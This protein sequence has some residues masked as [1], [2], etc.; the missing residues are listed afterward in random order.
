LI[1]VHLNGDFIRC[2]DMAAIQQQLTV[3]RNKLSICQFGV[4]EES[5]QKWT[6]FQMT[7]P[8]EY[9]N[10]RCF[11][12]KEFNTNN[13][14]QRVYLCAKAQERFKNSNK[15]KHFRID[16]NNYRKISSA[17]HYL[18]K[19]TENRTL[20]LA[21]T[22]PQWKAGFNPYKNENTLNECFSRF[23]ENLVATYDCKGYIAVRE[24]GK[25]DRRYHYHLLVNIPFVPFARLNAAWCHAIRDI[26]EFSKNA[27]TTNKENRLIS[28]SE[29]SRAVRYVCKY[30]SKSKN[31][32]SKSRVIFI[33]NNLFRKPFAVRNSEYNLYNHTGIM[34]LETELL[35]YKSL[36]VF[37]INDYCTAFR[38]NSNKDFDKICQEI[39]YPLFY[40]TDKNI[41]LYSF[42]LNTS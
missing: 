40:I 6:D 14:G 21:L 12:C 9:L 8:K 4:Y 32:C 34:N 23:V 37:K 20:F 39:I 24:L 26:C 3:S 1:N 38:I 41:D 35:K 15:T 7:R 42:P 18:M 2:P 22:F 16:N 27:L 17:A 25:I 19:T 30:I 10:K 29:S 31:Q 28:L 13:D 36:S 33:S 5:C 11:L